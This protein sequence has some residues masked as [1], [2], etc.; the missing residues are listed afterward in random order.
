MSRLLAPADQRRGWWLAASMA[1][2]AAAVGFGGWSLRRFD[3]NA[4]DS[5]FLPCLFQ[6]FTGLYCPGCGTTRALHALVHGDIA[7]ALAMN[8]LLF[9]LVPLLGAVLWHASGRQ[10]PLP[11]AAVALLLG[12]WFWLALIGGYW[13]LRN[14]PVWPFTMLAPG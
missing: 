4:A 14:V 3:P 5:P 8:P 9:V 13:L 12:P 10:L 2:A 1:G 7:T 11:R 6:A